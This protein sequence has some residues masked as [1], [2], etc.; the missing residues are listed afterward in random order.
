MKYLYECCRCG[1]CCL[2]EPCPIAKSMYG[3]DIEQCPALYYYVDSDKA[4]CLIAGVVPVGDGCCIKARAYKD[5]IEYD[6]A[7]LPPELKIREAQKLRKGK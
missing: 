3:E 4:V 2:Y 7:S 6:F 5:G 1:F